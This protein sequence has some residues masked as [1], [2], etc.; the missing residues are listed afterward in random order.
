[1]AD[2][3]ISLRELRP[4]DLITAVQPDGNSF[5]AVYLGTNGI[6]VDFRMEGSERRIRRLASRLG[7]PPQHGYYVIK[8]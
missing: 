5:D 2:A 1:M 4:G 3:V 7:I 8:R 6:M